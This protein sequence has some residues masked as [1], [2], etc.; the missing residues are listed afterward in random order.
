[1]AEQ[2]PASSD[3]MLK[4]QMIERRLEETGEKARLEEQLR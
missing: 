4:K 2:A 1:M 3:I